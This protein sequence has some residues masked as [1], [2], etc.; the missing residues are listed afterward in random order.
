MKMRELEQTNIKCVRKFCD[1]IGQRINGDRVKYDVVTS[2]SQLM[3]LV[4]N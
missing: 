2:Y 4:K 1:E 3:T